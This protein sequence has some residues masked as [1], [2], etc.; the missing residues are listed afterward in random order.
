MKARTLGVILTGMLA[1]SACSVSEPPTAALG[2]TPTLPTAPK[3]TT[4]LD[5]LVLSKPQWR[6]G[7]E[8][9][10][11]DGYAVRVSEITGILAKFE[12]LDAPG[13]WF[14]N[15]GFFRETSQS[16]GTPRQVVFRSENPD[17][18]FYTLPL[19]RPLVYVEEYLRDK[20]LIRHQTSW[21][22]E[23][24]ERITVPAGTFD[25]FVVV[26]RKRSLTSD[27]TAYERW[28]YAPAVKNYVRMEYRYGEEPEG[29]R[30]L[31]SSKLGN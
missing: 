31:M 2:T 9:H 20:D 27:W 17:P 1:L 14:V 5:S 18:S 7:D 28:W 3:A 23:S 11:S 4:T 25:T 29:A 10:Y 6:V 19:G 22:V 30:V 15:N 13:Q 12:R 16:D 8:W 24:R 21:V 26:I